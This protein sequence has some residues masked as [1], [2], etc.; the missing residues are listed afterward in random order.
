MARIT[1]V[2]CEQVVPNRFALV[3]VAAARARALN[4]GEAPRVPPDGDKPTVIA[5]REIAAAADDPAWLIEWLQSLE[6]DED[7]E[8]PGLVNPTAKATPSVSDARDAARAHADAPDAA[9]PPENATHH[10]LTEMERSHDGQ[11][12]DTRLQR[13]AHRQH[14]RHP[15]RV[16]A[17]LPLGAGLHR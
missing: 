6:R 3:H 9:G 10:N 2:D 8:A 4:R 12:H 11:A 5:L 13:E 17:A 15:R 7:A 16:P 14:Q 1:T